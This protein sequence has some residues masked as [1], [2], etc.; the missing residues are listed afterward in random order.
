M[1]GFQYIKSNRIKSN[2]KIQSDD[3]TDDDVIAY[4]REHERVNKRALEKLNKNKYLIFAFGGI[5]VLLANFR[6]TM[7]LAFM[8]SA[9]GLSVFLIGLVVFTFIQ[10]GKNR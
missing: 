9:S 8:L 1:F 7:E 5:L 6:S 10:K 4:F 2:S 3:F